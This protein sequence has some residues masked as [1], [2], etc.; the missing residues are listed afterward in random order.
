MCNSQ[1]EKTALVRHLKEYYGDNLLSVIFYG[2]HLKG[3][4]DEIDVF[5]I[6][7]KPTDLVKLNRLADFI[8]DIKEP[9]ERKY[10][11]PVAFELYIKEDA[12]SFHA[13]Y[14]DIARAYEIAYDKG[15]YFANLLSKMTDPE[16]SM[17]YVQ[18]LTT[19]EII[20]S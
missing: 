9:I 4:L 14:L 20:E 3:I 18:Y 16:V 5:V 2:A 13:V 10:G 17:H 11:C 19:I 8:E 12:D 1:E 15:N 6:I 7:E